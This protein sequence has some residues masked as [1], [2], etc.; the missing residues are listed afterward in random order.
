MHLLQVKTPKKITDLMNQFYY[1][2]KSKY[3]DYVQVFTDGLKDPITDKTGSAVSVPRA[4]VQISKRVSN[5]LS[6]YTV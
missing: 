3:T 2:T 6:V 1:D 5:L 4:K